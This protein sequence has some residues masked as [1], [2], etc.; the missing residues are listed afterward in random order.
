MSRRRPASYRSGVDLKAGAH[1]FVAEPLAVDTAIAVALTV[2][3]QIQV[4]ADVSAVDRLLLLVVTG[5]VALRRK[6][7]LL[8]ALVVAGAVALMAI[9]PQQPS[10]FGEYLALMLTAYTVAE[11]CRLR[12]AVL[13]GLALAAGIVV[14]DLASSDYDSAGAIAGDLVVPALIWGVGR[15]VHYQFRRVD[16]SQELIAELESDREELARLAV[17]AE[18]AH[19][20]R[21]L[22]DVVTHSVSVVVIQAQG[23]QRI[24]ADE[25]DPLLRKSLADIETAG[26]TALNEMRRLLGLLRDQDQDR[27]P[28]PGLPDLPALLARVR[29]A[30]LAVELS[31]DGPPPALSAQVGLSIYRIVQEA[32]TN[33]LKYAPRSTVVVQVH[34]GA[35][36]VQVSVVDDGPE[37][38]TPSGSGSGRGLAG[39]RERAALLGGMV[40]TGALPGGGFRVFAE[41]PTEAAA[42]R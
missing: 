38:A 13:A 37:T 23:A 39:M 17:A 42:A 28:E 35:G 6:A 21:E 31:S 9:T 18:R 26:R 4:G 11:R 14:H 16:R 8:T 36:T 5:V 7:P 33:A 10:V 15:I 20:A 32:L 34:H 12:V 40:E 22:H 3:A 2:L 24:L 27:V 19:L 30:G 1:R 29:G 25:D 41:L